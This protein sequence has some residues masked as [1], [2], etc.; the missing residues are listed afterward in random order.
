[1]N[2]SLPIYRGMFLKI[3]PQKIIP[4]IIIAMLTG[5]L[6]AQFYSLISP[7]GKK[8]YFA[9]IKMR[10]DIGMR[11]RTDWAYSIFDGKVSAEKYKER[12]LKYDKTGKL[13]EIENYSPD[14]KIL[15]IVIVNYENDD[16]PLEEVT[17]RPEGPVISKGN[18][19]Y[20]PDRLLSEYTRYNAKRLI[21]FKWVAERDTAAGEIVWMKYITPDSIS[22]KI[23]YKY[24]GDL[25]GLLIG[26]T[27]YIGDSL[28]SNR[29]IYWSDDPVRKDQEIT[30]DKAG[31]E[32][33]R[34]KYEYDYTGNNNKIKIVY[35]NQ[36]NMDKYIY[37]YGA[38]NLMTGFIDHDNEGNIAG[39]HIY[40][41]EYY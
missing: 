4:G 14:G 23:K 36:Q 2:W 30:F 40:T 35:P 13:A 38:H 21:D 15:S 5:T 34:W 28:Y 16:L 9:D 27:I 18:Y 11:S 29:K 33:F 1:M 12:L 31:R 10:T 26:E 20:S 19:R 3:I 25:S 37:A 8:E 32:L 7:A 17:Y 39:Y 24:T 22:Q 41:Y 6:H